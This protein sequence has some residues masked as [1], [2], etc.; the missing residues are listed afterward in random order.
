M[1]IFFLNHPVCLC[2][3]DDRLFLKTLAIWFNLK[4]CNKYCVLVWRSFICLLQIFQ[5]DFIIDTLN[6]IFVII[7]HHPHASYSDLLAYS[8][9][10][11]ILIYVHVSLMQNKN[12]FTFWTWFS[13]I[14]IKRVK[15]RRLETF[16]SPYID[17][18]TWCLECFQLYQKIT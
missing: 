8:V 1:S 5:I 16:Y 3:S 10:R 7:K 4:K 18:T 17:Q 12:K 9:T 14:Y 6:N 13:L 15:A 2:R 11:F